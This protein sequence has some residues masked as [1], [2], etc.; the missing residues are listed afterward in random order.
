MAARRAGSGFALA[1]GLGDARQ[2]TAAVSPAVSVA[3]LVRICDSSLILALHA[4]IPPARSF[5]R[6]DNFGIDYNLEIVATNKALVQSQ[7]AQCA[8]VLVARDRERGD[9]PSARSAKAE[10]GGLVQACFWV[11]PER[12]LQVQSTSFPPQ[13]ARRKTPRG[14]SATTQNTVYSF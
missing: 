14:K 3:A 9:Q 2:L 12:K 5:L 1:E 13:R 7:K 6:Y 11:H 4:C 8:V 10:I